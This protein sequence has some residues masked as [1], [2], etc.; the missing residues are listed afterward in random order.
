[1]GRGGAIL[2]AGCIA[3]L[4]LPVAAL[5][6]NL[7]YWMAAV[8]ALAFFT[9]VYL[10]A[11]RPRPGEA[12][13]ADAIETAR[14]GTARALAAEAAAAV[15]RLRRAVGQIRDPAMRD[16]IAGLAKTGE[17]VVKAVRADPAKAMAVRRLLTFYL[18]NAASLAEGWLSL[19][20][21]RTPAAD[22]AEQTRQTMRGLNEAFSRFADDLSTPA[23]ETLDL[24]LKVLN[25]AL[26]A[27]LEIP[28]SPP[29]AA[30]ARP[31]PN[32]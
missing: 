10:V 25:D 14:S 1:V 2:T 26:K 28:V 7:P 21:R 9:G 11:R 18:P 6:L 30:I 24:D 22:R 5:A 4:V 23:M 19:E 17:A 3:A 12:L 31:E 16:E 20:Q 8:L 13:D 15:D 29:T 32:R 27:D